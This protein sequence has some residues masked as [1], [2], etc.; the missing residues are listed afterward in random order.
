MSERPQKQTATQRGERVS[1]QRV[2]A[3]NEPNE[4]EEQPTKKQTDR[5]LRFSAISIAADRL[6]AAA[7]RSLRKSERSIRHRR[8]ARNGHVHIAVS[9]EERRIFHDA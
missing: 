3:R 7:R 1:H 5:C 6:H 2:V 8:S 9:E 4:T